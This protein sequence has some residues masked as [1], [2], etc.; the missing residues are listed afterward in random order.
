METRFLLVNFHCWLLLELWCLR[1][2][3]AG[4]LAILLGNNTKFLLYILYRRFFSHRNHLNLKKK[5][6]I[7]SCYFIPLGI[8]F[9]CSPIWSDDFFSEYIMI[10]NQCP[11]NQS[12]WKAPW[13]PAVATTAKK[14]KTNFKPFNLILSKDFYFS[15][16]N[17]TRCS[18][19]IFSLKPLFVGWNGTG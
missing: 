17:L 12:M 8:R 18:I 4:H 7:S 13:W 19:R 5:T 2:K 11:L 10:L 9:L 15:Y 1:A 3:W 6:V 16:C 14:C